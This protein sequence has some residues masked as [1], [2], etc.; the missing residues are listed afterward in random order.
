MG[1]GNQPWSNEGGNSY[2][3][4]WAGSLTKVRGPHTLKFGA[5]YRIFQFNGPNGFNVSGN[6]TFGKGF[7]QGPNP[8]AA[9]ALIGDG[10]ASLLTGLGTGSAQIIPRVFT[11]PRLPIQSEELL[12]LVRAPGYRGR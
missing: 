7:T 9:G 10:V 8:T 4:Q 2:Q 3:N 11:I 1:T 6:Y 5:D 12:R